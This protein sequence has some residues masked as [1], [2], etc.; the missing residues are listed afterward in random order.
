MP[1]TCPRFDKTLTN[2]PLTDSPTWIQEML[3]HPKTAELVADG[4]P[5]QDQALPCRG[6]F[7]PTTLNFWLGFLRSSSSTQYIEAASL[8]LVGWLRFGEECEW[9]KRL[10]RVEQ[11]RPAWAPSA[12]TCH[13]HDH[14]YHRHHHCE[15]QNH[16]HDHHY[17]HH[18]NI[19]ILGP[20]L[21]FTINLVNCL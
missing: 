6:I 5:K 10:D 18:S 17:H 1:M 7:G 13:H 15:I 14:N 3:T 19:I 12:S 8:R 11:C 20:P 9:L 16:H 2:D 21:E 4:V